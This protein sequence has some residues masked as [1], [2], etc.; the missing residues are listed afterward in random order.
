MSAFRFRADILKSSRN[1][2]FF[3]SISLFLPQNS[4]FRRLGNWTQSP[5]IIG[6]V[7]FLLR[8]RSR[9]Q[10]IPV[11]FPVSREWGCGDR[12]DDDCVRHHALFRTGKFRGNWPIACNWRDL[13]LAFRSLRRPF[14]IKGRFRAGCLLPPDFPFSDEAS[15]RRGVI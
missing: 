3:F 4:L 13:P 7:R 2:L 11:L 5:V 12:F 10:K 14:Q 8:V 6:F 1:S 9:N 15:V